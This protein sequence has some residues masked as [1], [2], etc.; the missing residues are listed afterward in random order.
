MKIRNGFVTNS[1]SSS[2]ILGFQSK[3]SVTQEFLDDPAA[4]GHVE[5][6]LRECLNASS[7]NWNNILD[8]VKYEECDQ[9]EWD[10]YLDG[11][12][13]EKCK[14]KLDEI[15]KKFE[16]DAIGKEYFVYLDCEG[17]LEYDVVPYLNC[18]IR[19][20]SHH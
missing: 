10:Y 5:E 12:P 13:K 4:K 17:I 1:S 18:C 16:S 20:Y 11:V 19:G 8:V 14:E 9:L 2:F 3:D 15:L 6:L 7:M